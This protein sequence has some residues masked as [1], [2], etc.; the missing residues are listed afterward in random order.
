MDFRTRKT[1]EKPE[2]TI[3]ERNYKLT[4]KETGITEDGKKFRSKKSESYR[5]SGGYVRAFVIVASVAAAI[6]GIGFWEYSTLHRTDIGEPMTLE[7]VGNGDFSQVIEEDSNS[8]GQ[9]A[10]S[11]PPKSEIPKQIPEKDETAPGASKPPLSEG[12]ENETEETTE[13]EETVP[14]N[15]EGP[16]ATDPETASIVAEIF[17]LVNE[18]R[19]KQGLPAYE[20]DSTLEV[21]ALRKSQHMADNGYFDHV[22]PDGK[23]SWNW[24]QEDGVASAYTCWGENIF[25]SSWESSAEEIMDAWMNSSGHRA[26]I[27]SE[28]N[29]SI[30]IGVVTTADG[31]R[32]ATQVFGCQ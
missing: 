19:A 21:Y 7:N 27:L 32:Y 6:G 26:A 4:N 8:G 11:T 30:G 29:T 14:E 3:N 5:S 24:M 2:K 10:V 1:P 13:P 16:T 20:Y 15:P 22:D 31:Q 17:V 28:T 25:M 18:E 23:T 9:N 12:G